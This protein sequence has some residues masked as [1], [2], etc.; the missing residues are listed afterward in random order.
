MAGRRESD[1][2]TKG[3]ITMSTWRRLGFLGVVLGGL[4]PALALPGCGG[5]EAGKSTGPNPEVEIVPPKDAKGNT[6]PI[7]DEPA[8]PA[9]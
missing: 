3:R 5:G 4:G 6:F 7:T 8:T 1:R 2:W 9:K